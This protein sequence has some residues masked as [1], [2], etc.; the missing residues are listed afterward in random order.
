MN[1]VGVKRAKNKE[2]KMFREGRV[3]AIGS[4]VEPNLWN[5]CRKNEDPSDLIFRVSQQDFTDFD[6]Q[7]LSN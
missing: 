4:L 7:K 1:F 5:Y 2:F 6:I 3:N